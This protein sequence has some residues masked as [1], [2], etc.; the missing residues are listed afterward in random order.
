[1]D[2]CVHGRANIWALKE[3]GCTHLIVSTA[4]GSLKEEVQPGQLVILDGL[5]DMTKKRPTT[6]HDGVTPGAPN[7]ILHLPME[8]I[9]S[10]ELRKFLITGAE[11]LGIPHHASGTAMVIEGPRFSTKA[12][13][14]LFRMWGASVVNMTTAP[15][16]ML[17][18]LP[19]VILLLD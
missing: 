16:V 1:M 3:A 14:N 13:S 6:F 8:P 12:E 11:E 10:E 15:E 2:L 19:V 7:G 17:F 4:C 18:S 9:F 5:I